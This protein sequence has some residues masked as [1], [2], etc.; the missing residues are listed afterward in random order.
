M[1]SMQQVVAVYREGIRKTSQHQIFLVLYLQ[2]TSYSD[3]D[4][5]QTPHRG[6][7]NLQGRHI[8]SNTS[9]TRHKHAG[10]ASAD[11]ITSIK[12]KRLIS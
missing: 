11:I 5:H 3:N 9:L 4:L 2:K 8:D 1:L 12:E 10:K 6:R 7:S